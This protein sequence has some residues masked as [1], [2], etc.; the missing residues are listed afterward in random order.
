M[1]GTQYIV[2]EYYLLIACPVACLKVIVLI[3]VCFGMLGF[4]TSP[5][6]SQDP[7]T[8]LEIRMLLKIG[9]GDEWWGREDGSMKNVCLPSPPRWLGIFEMDLCVHICWAW[10]LG[11]RFILMHHPILRWL[12]EAKALPED[13]DW[14]HAVT[15]RPEMAQGTELI[16]CLSYAWSLWQSKYLLSGGAR[17]CPLC[18]VYSRPGKQMKNMEA[19]PLRRGKVE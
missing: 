2:S 7:Q 18:W 1:P 15:P 10:S 14:W 13:S 9:W 11:R 4:L 6:T 5:P 17:N 3:W 19:E 16:S 8:T 12:R